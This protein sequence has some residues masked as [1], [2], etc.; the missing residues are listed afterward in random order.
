MGDEFNRKAAELY[1]E[2]AKDAR[3][4]SAG[5]CSSTSVSFSFLRYGYYLL[6]YLFYLHL[7]F[8]VL[9]IV[10]FIMNV[11]IVV[12]DAERRTLARGSDASR[13][14]RGTM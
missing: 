4:G 6:F 9:F 1:A 2:Q 13:W 7:F 11:V 12:F 5:G 14:L 10:L 8:I 3:P